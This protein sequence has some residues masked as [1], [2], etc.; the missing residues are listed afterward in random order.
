MDTTMCHT[1]HDSRSDYSTNLSG[2]GAQKFHRKSE[3]PAT[4]I[5]FHEPRPGG[6]NHIRKILSISGGFSIATLIFGALRNSTVYFG[7][8]RLASV[9]IVLFSLAG[10]FSPGTAHA[11]EVDIA[12]EAFA[13][14]GAAVGVNLQSTEKELVKSVVRCTVMRKQ[15]VGRCARDELI[16]RLP[17][18]AQPLASCLIK[19]GSVKACAL[20]AA[21]ARLPEETKQLA[22][23]IATGTNPSQ[24]GKRI[25]MD[26]LS[27]A[28]RRVL[29]KAFGAFESLKVDVVA[30]NPLTNTPG[31]IQNIIRFAEGLRENDWA[32][33]THS[34]ATEVLKIAGKTLTRIFLTPVLASA[35]DPAVDA[36]IQYR[37]DL[38]LKLIMA[39]DAGNARRVSE[40]AAEAFIYFNTSLIPA[41]ALMP[42]GGLKQATCGAAAKAIASVV[43]FV[44][45]AGAHAAR[46][47]EHFMNRMLDFVTGNKKNC[48]NREQ[49]Y[50]AHFAS[51][52]YHAVTAK[53]MGQKGVRRLEQLE[54][55]LYH[56]CRRHFEPCS[57]RFTMSLGPFGRLGKKSTSERITDICDPVRDRFRWEVD[58]LAHQ[59]RHAASEF[60]RSY[61][62]LQFRLKHGQSCKAH[63]KRHMAADCRRVLGRIF[64]GENAHCRPGGR[65][66]GRAR[67]IR[68]ICASLKA[69]ADCTFP[70]PT[71]WKSPSERMDL[72][73]RRPTLPVP[74]RIQL[75]Q[76]KRPVDFKRRPVLPGRCGG[77]KVGTPPNCFCPPGTKWSSRKKTCALSRVSP[78]RPRMA[79]CPDGSRAAIYSLCRKRCAD[80]SV[81][82]VFAKCPPQEVK[83]ERWA[84]CPDG[85]RA[86]FYA[87]CRKRCP[88]GS[89]VRV[90]AKCPPQQVKRERWTRC[91][92]GSR[93]RFYALCRKRCPDGSVVRVHAKC[94][95]Q[96]VKRTRWA[97]CP[98]GSRAAIYSLC[99]KRCPD[100][101]VVRVFSK[102]GSKSA[103]RQCPLVRTC[104][105]WAKG[106]P[107]TLS[108]RC[109]RY[110]NVRQCP[111]K[112]K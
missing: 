112:V 109:I 104:V 93:A 45:D 69:H 95:P 65:S 110:Q 55:D 88:D 83:R 33:I 62:R 81:V 21:Q 79:R 24:C 29:N 78:E 17:E 91:P 52:R 18:D 97:R 30:R 103:Q 106:R 92:D 75:D 20:S 43:G 57:K 80:G 74:P 46:G 10:L 42:E 60:E 49:H 90:H 96:Q 82:R 68:H 86:R 35:L 6:K 100:G 77:G 87:L 108:G 48:G 13:I 7:V 12:V 51:C 64:R 38:F 25:A 85:S 14:G 15:P 101:R 89:M 16:K 5:M 22:S 11:D 50:A 41:C 94:P 26:Q 84:R 34:S 54:G 3:Q 37:T 36:M 40:L 98:D 111:S 47:A 107:G 59:V 56:Q 23:C 61:P 102:C 1:R 70:V 73:K 99:R 72:I 27:Q 4:T 31:S 66:R 2:G 19:G 76:S 67:T 63:A 71:V 53:Q 105:Q 8:L 39:A 58:H 44:G 32:K 9:L 28:E